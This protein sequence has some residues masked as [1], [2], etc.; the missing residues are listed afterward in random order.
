VL[1][2]APTDGDPALLERLIAN[3][4]DNALRHNDSRA[5]VEVSTGVD[6]GLSFLAVENTGP[7]VPAWA[8]QRLFEPFSRVEELRRAEDGEHHGLGL[9]IVRSIAI[10]HQAEV[11]ARPREGGGLAV[12]VRFAGARE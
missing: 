5:A 4:V 2:S 9:S 12:T 11:E 1:S 10:A 8:L 7:V 6:G 3:L